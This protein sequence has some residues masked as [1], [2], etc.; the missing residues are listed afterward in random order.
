M[1]G[2]AGAKVCNLGHGQNPTHILCETAN[3]CDPW[4]A[5]PKRKAR[6]TTGPG[7]GRLA[8]DYL[9]AGGTSVQEPWAISAAMPMLSPSVGCG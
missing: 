5:I 1:L 6:T 9:R 8:A 4:P 3:F 7:F 2:S